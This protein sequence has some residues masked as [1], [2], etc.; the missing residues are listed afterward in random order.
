MKKEASGR[1]LFMLSG[2]I[3]AYKA[4]HVLSRLKQ[5]GHAIETV[6][7]PS[8][9]HFVGEATL[10]G[11]TGRPV[12]K[13]MF[14]TGVAM[15]HIDLVRWADI[16]I[17]C[18][19]TANTINKLANGT[20]DDLLTTLFLAHDFKKPWLI[21]PAMNTMMY[22]HPVT[23]SSI[24]KLKEM[25]CEILETASGVLACGEIGDGRLLDPDQILKELELHLSKATEARSK[26]KIRTETGA[27]A[28][29][30]AD[31][32]APLFAKTL[33][34]L[35]TAGGTKEPIDPVRALTNTSTGATGAMIAEAFLGLGHKVDYVASHDAVKPRAQELGA[36]NR[37]QLATFETFCE[38]DQE[39][40]KLLK[41]ERYDAIIHAAAVSDYRLANGAESKK[42]D[43]KEDLVLRFTRNP[44]ILNTLRDRSKNQE[45]KIVAF[46]LTVNEAVEPRV[47]KMFTDSNPDYIVA[48]DL[49]NYPN[50]SLYPNRTETT[51]AAQTVVTGETRESLAQTLAHLLERT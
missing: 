41:T 19:A 46:K 7:T 24:K 27:S 10:E 40:D 29:A 2:S 16:V 11:L 45:T 32:T 22:H 36:A 20:G 5:A 37:Y 34:V 35:V 23:Q 43:S 50:W 44:K 25:G 38:L 49:T 33:R 18:P 31:T 4:A 21:T 30:D 39:L 51:T 42:I 47:T 28:D 48:N 12:R 13:S 15:S 3:A 14:G 1:V 9:L 17:V 8:A 26:T 6:A